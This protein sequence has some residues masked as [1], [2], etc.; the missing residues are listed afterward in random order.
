MVTNGVVPDLY[1]FMCRHCECTYLSLT[2]WLSCLYGDKWPKE[3]P[4][5]KSITQSVKRLSAKKDKIKKSPNSAAKDEKMLDFLNEEYTL[6]A[7]FK[8]KWQNL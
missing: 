1:D 2:K 7:V 3:S 4:T 6:P 5:V 8:I